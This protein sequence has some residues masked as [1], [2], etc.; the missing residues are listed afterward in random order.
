MRFRKIVLHN[1]VLNKTQT[2]KNKENFAHRFGENYLRNHLV[3]SLQD[4]I[5]AGKVGALR[6]SHWSSIFQSKFLSEA[7][8]TFTRRVI[9]VSNIYEG[10]F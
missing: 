2:T 8:V 4:R 3:K 10:I 7:S 6:I 1:K 9:R 5:E